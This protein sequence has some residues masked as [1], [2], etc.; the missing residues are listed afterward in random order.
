M[1]DIRCRLAIHKV[2]CSAVYV[3]DGGSLEDI[4]VVESLVAEV[5]VG[6]VSDDD[7]VDGVY[8]CVDEVEGDVSRRDGG[9]DDNNTLKQISTPLEISW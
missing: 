4:G 2:D 3:T 9:S 6:S 1:V 8:G 5:A 7:R